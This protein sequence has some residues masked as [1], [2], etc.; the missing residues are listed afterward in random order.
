MAFMP[1][2][3]PL[4]LL[5]PM[6]WLSACGNDEDSGDGRNESRWRPGTCE[7]LADHFVEACPGRDRATELENCEY[8]LAYFAPD[9]LLDRMGAICRMRGGRRNRV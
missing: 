8:S 1:L 3:H 6:L 2:R 9:G 7:E 5:F 4:I